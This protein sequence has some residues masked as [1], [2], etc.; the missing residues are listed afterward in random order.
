MTGV[1][2]PNGVP[3]DL[4]DRL[5]AAG[6]YASIRADSLRLAPHLFTTEADLDR[7]SEVVA[8]G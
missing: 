4:G 2:F 1:F 7:L 5:R 8:A 6:V 3:V